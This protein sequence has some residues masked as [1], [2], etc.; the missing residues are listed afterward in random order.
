MSKKNNP[1]G[2]TEKKPERL[3]PLG[4]TVTTHGIRGWLKLK[5]YNPKTA[6]A[7]IETVVL[8]KGEVYSHHLLEASKAHKGHL[9][10]KLEGI[11]RIDDA[12]K[13]VGSILSVTEEALRP[14][15]PGEYYYYEAIGLQV[16][17]TQGRWLGI[18]TRIWSKEGGDLYVVQ[19][20]A[21]EYLIPAVREMIEKIDIPGG[22][23]IVNP[24]PGLLDL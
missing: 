13:W 11:D 23:I 16:Y 9:L 19:G 12:E 22:K 15:E 20:N 18:L 6:L 3:V 24:P 14:L 5:L 17:D 10:I 1:I 4:E 8:K 7:L 2:A 21:K